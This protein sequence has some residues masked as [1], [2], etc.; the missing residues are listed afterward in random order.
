M[1]FSPGMNSIKFKD[2]KKKKQKI[3]VF[4]LELIQSIVAEVNTK[5]GEAECQFYR[6]GLSY[7]E[8]SQRLPEIQLSRFLYCHGELK[9][10][11]GQVASLSRPQMSLNA[12]AHL[13]QHISPPTRSSMSSCSSWPWC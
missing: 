8:E 6:R 4:Q 12:P 11:K 10:T 2:K 9:S 5:T 7:L 3:T 1:L 13:K